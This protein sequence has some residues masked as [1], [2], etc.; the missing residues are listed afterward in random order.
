MLSSYIFV[1]FSSGF[2][3]NVENVLLVVK[4]TQKKI[5]KGILYLNLFFYAQK[6]KQYVERVILSEKN[7][8]FKCG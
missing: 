7:I 1:K 4:I 6:G 2:G 5:L 3:K 8:I